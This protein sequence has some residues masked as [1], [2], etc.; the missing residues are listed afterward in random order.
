[1]DNYRKQFYKKLHNSGV[2]SMQDFL[3]SLSFDELLEVD[4]NTGSLNQIHHIVE[5]YSTPLAVTTYEELYQCVLDNIVHPED[6][7]VYE[8][9]MNPDHFFERLE[10]S[11]IRNFDCA[12]MRFKLQSGGYRY[13]EQIIIA[14]DDFDLAPGIFR[15]YIYDVHNF[16]SR[17]LDQIEGILDNQFSEYDEI[18]GLFR[19]DAFARH[20]M[21]LLKGKPDLKWVFTLL[22]I[23]NFTFYHEWFGEEQTASL[24][25]KIGAIVKKYAEERKGSCCIDSTN[26]FLLLT[27]YDEE[28]TKKLFDEV[29]NLVVSLGFSSAFMPA[30]GLAYFEKGVTIADM[31]ERLR[32][33]VRK[34]ES[35]IKNRIVTY[36]PLIRKQNQSDHIAISEYMAAFRNGEI[37]FFLQPQVNA[38]NGKIVGAEALSR[39]VK[40]DGKM[41]GPGHFIPLLEK[42]G[43]I[44]DLDEYIWEE[45][46]KYQR[47]LLDKGINPVPISLNVSRADIFSLDIY[48]VFTNLVKKY[49]LPTKYIKIEITESAY[50]ETS[51]LISV[52]VNNLRRAGFSVLM[53]D[54]GSG[55]SS[56]NMLSSL[57]VDVIK[58]DARFLELK[59][60]SFKKG[61]SIL[62]S[63]INMAK[64]IYLPI[65]VEGVERKDQLDFLMELGCRYIQG[66]YFYKPMP[67]DKFEEII[68]D[69]NRVEH[70]EITAK[71][72]EQFH[73]REFLDKNIYSDAMLNNILGP[74]A[75]YAL[76]D[77]H[78]DIIRFNEEFYHA[79]NVPDFNQKLEN[80]D[81]LMP[82][83]D[84]P[85]MIQTLK[86]ARR[87]RL[88]GA[89]GIYRFARIDGTYSYFHIHFFYLGKSKHGDRF[90]GS[91]ENIGDIMSLAEQRKL[92]TKYG[93]INTI[94]VSQVYDRWVF[95]S[96]AYHLCELFGISNEQFEKEL[97]DGTN[98]N[99]FEHP[100][101]VLEG[102]DTFARIADKSGDIKKQ[103]KV[104]DKDGN[105]R[106]V[107]L[108]LYSATADS[109]NIKYLMLIDILE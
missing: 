54:F 29:R 83:D 93:K 56:L 67:I 55:Y 109:L 81:S 22:S 51:E 97:N 105:L 94:F 98:A 23:E 95:S 13:I 66:Y 108:T 60:Q 84:G 41:I 45:V 43:F 49:N 31:L 88:N 57:K 73:I 65:I 99:R 78:V 71:L 63:V 87:D 101:N 8:Q 42:Y 25:S 35:D 20:G 37:Q 80:I 64:Q 104:Y 86:D 14:G 4:M 47:S 77:E 91:A 100:E 12:I 72:N 38:S 10:K 85:K 46:C 75:I 76:H 52:L 61:I 11:D 70:L 17:N 27:T 6:K 69:E 79:V 92:V 1:M 48:H 96:A 106:P 33:A 39:W 34:A 32:I 19:L 102:M 103:F 53:D 24:I 15:V 58:L 7:A 3:R 62:E 40:P 5:K 89:S 26:S 68:K 2:L 21:A 9:M 30:I 50:T 107:A 59:G 90:Y 28:G 74:V 16:V 82:E 18:S 36:D 44:I